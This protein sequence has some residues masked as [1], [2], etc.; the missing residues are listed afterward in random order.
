M[1]ISYLHGIWTA[2]LLGVFLVIGW[3]AYR[4]RNAARFEEAANIPLREDFD[5]GKPEANRV[6]V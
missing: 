3:W 4:A 1:T 5:L 6:D 2:L